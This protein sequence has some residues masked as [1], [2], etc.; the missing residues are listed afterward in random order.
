MN[1]ADTNHV[2]TLLAR[3]VTKGSELRSWDVWRPIAASLSRWV[4]RPE[5]VETI[6]QQT[7]RDTR[8]PVRFPKLGWGEADAA[9]WTHHSPVSEAACSNWL[10]SS[11]YSYGPAWSVCA[12]ADASPSIYVELTERPVGKADMELLLVSLR[13][14]VAGGEAVPRALHDLVSALTP[15]SDAALAA[16]TVRPFVRRHG[17]SV[18]RSIE[19]LTHTD[20]DREVSLDAINR[21]SAQMD[22]RCRVTSDPWHPLLP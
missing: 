12:K 6:S 14:D 16:Y 2:V 19:E 5:E 11:T 9:K 18:M 4:V 20:I 1:L 7:L 13:V 3:P 15:H 21:A 22:R 17:E 8:K 10:F